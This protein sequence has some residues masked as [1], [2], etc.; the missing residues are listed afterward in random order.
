MV[1]IFFTVSSTKSAHS[2]KSDNPCKV[3]T[4]HVGVV[5]SVAFSPDGKTIASSG[6]TF[7]DSRTGELILWDAVSGKVRKSLQGH[8]SMVH[9]VAFSPKGNFLASGDD[10]GTIIIWDSETGEIKK[11]ILGDPLDTGMCVA[12]SP[13]GKFLAAKSWGILRL[14][15]TKSWSVIE[16]TSDLSEGLSIAFTPDSRFIAVAGSRG[17]VRLWDVTTRQ[18]KG[19]IDGTCGG[20]WASPMSLPSTVLSISVSP[21]GKLL[22]AGG[23]FGTVEVWDI[24][25]GGSLWYSERPCGLWV[26]SL[27][28]SPDSKK[29][30]VG[31]DCSTVVV[32]ASKNGNIEEQF[33]SPS[34]E[35]SSVTYSNDGNLL[36]SG[37]YDKMVR[38][39]KLAKTSKD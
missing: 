21:D 34:G 9:T 33:E 35:V 11:K 20:W 39:W 13:D 14:L 3:L 5:L 6:G 15:D 2:A 36:A 25:S 8:N 31:S 19:S 30:A 1:A 16:E 10:D 37:S 38:I 22:A 24:N 23:A 26:R 17:K 7:R 29:L 27:T 32:L 4:G 28:F 18:L 12:F